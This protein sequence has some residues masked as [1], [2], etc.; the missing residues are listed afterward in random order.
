MLLKS[1][2]KLIKSTNEHA[3]Q[4]K[5]NIL[6]FTEFNEDNLDNNIIEDIESYFFYNNKIQYFIEGAVVNVSF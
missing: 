6:K 4:V 5:N 1:K 3:S 2:L